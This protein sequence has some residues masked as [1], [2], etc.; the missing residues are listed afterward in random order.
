LLADNFSCFFNFLLLN[1][2]NAKIKITQNYLQINDAMKDVIP[3]VTDRDWMKLH[4]QIH[5]LST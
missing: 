1:K 3:H 5:N 2:E 4:G